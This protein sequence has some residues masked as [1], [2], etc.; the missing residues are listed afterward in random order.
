MTLFEFLTVGSFMVALVA[1]DPI[2]LV[3]YIAAGSMTRTL[4]AAL[5]VASAW[6]IVTVLAYGVIFA[7]YRSDV[8]AKLIVTLV[9]LRVFGALIVAGATFALAGAL[10]G[11][12]R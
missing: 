2:G 5:G 1:L 9:P 7:F 8:E 3:G 12:W 11:R 4:R 10:K 6:A